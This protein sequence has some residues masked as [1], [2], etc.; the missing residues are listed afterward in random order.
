VGQIVDDEN[1][2]TYRLHFSRFGDGSNGTDV[3]EAGCA[4]MGSSTSFVCEIGF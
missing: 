2:K 3:L 4:Q 1:A